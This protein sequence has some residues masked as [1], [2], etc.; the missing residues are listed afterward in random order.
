L[1][2]SLLKRLLL[3]VIS[4]LLFVLISFLLSVFIA[5]KYSYN[6]EDILGME[7]ILLLI[8]SAYSF[9]NGT[10]S[11]ASINSVADLNN[12]PDSYYDV[13]NYA[14]EKQT[15]INSLFKSSL[16]PK[17]TLKI[18][19]LILSGFIITFISYFYDKIF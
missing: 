8:I 10:S 14:K 2:K 13:E 1:K 11:F 5:K 18:Q 4:T 3:V 17:I 19:I 9:F 7:G 12:P 16:I 15:E 6:A